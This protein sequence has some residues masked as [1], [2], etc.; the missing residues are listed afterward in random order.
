VPFD[1]SK[2]LFTVKQD[3]RKPSLGHGAAPIS[4]DISL[5]IPYGR[6]HTF[7]GISACQGLS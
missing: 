3:R 5:A 6:E 4:S 1:S 7:D 2:P